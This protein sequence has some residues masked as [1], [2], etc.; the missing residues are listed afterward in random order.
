M[1]PGP[2]RRYPA[3]AN[4]TSPR[5]Q[6]RCCRAGALHHAVTPAQEGDRP[7]RRCRGASSLPRWVADQSWVGAAQAVQER[8]PPRVA[9]PHLDHSTVELLHPLLPHC[10]LPQVHRQAH[11]S[12]VG[13]S[14]YKLL[15]LP[16]RRRAP[17]PKRSKL[18]LAGS[19]G[20]GARLRLPSHRLA[21]PPVRHR[22]LR[23]SKLAE[24]RRTQRQVR[25]VH[26]S[27]QPPLLL[28]WR[29]L[30]DPFPEATR[31]TASFA[32]RLRGDCK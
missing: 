32:A 21:P 23:T 19:R 13:P 10:N 28:A 18:R 24:Q 25:I 14:L 6:P 16:P 1:R 12:V 5:A 15:Q 2:D 20:G 27:K 29:Q 26:G 4:S 31:V 22:R 7:G 17:P 9:L 8:A 11:R 30:L 3:A